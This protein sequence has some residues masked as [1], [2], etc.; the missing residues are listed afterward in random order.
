MTEKQIYAIKMQLNNTLNNLMD[1]ETFSSIAEDTPTDKLVMV[2][3]E[4]DR[5]LTILKQNILRSIV[6]LKNCKGTEDILRS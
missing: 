4:K 6:E 3:V 5:I 2:N 1:I